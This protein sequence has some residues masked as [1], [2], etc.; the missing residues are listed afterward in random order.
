MRNRWSSAPS[1]TWRREGVTNAMQGYWLI[2]MAANGLARST[3]FETLAELDQAFNA[4]NEEYSQ[5]LE[6]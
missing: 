4:L 3:K 2:T 6:S 1:D 5:W